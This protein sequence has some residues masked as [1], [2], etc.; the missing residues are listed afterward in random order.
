M[1]RRDPDLIPA[2]VGSFDGN[3]SVFHLYNARGVVREKDQEI[4]RKPGTPLLTRQ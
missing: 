4:G 1:G 2:I 3:L